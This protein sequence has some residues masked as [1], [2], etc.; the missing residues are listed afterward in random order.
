MPYKNKEDEK[1]F[2]KKWWNNLSPERKKEKQDKAN[3]RAKLVREFIANYKIK[4]G[5]IDCGYN[6]HHSALDFDHI[7]GDKSI[8]VCLAKS[9]DQAKKEIVKYE[10][11]CSNCHRIRT[12][13]RLYPCKPDIFEL[14]YEK[15]EE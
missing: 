7:G 15:V 4:A 10:V 13:N 8:N 12:Y 1:I 6:K 5:C 3:V 14:T 11:V 9:I 2:R